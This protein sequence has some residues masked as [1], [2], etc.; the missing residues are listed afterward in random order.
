VGHS[1]LILFSARFNIFGSRYFLLMYLPFRPVMLLCEAGLWWESILSLDGSFHGLATSV[2]G[3][4][5]KWQHIH[6]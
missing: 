5:E 6:S 2:G 1:L 3:M 4:P